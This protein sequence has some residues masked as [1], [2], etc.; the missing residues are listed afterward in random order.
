LARLGAFFAARAR[1]GVAYVLHLR[2]GGIMYL[3]EAVRHYRRAHAAFSATAALTDGR[4]VADLAFGDRD[5]ER[6]H[7]TDR[8]PAITADLVE[9]EAELAETEAERGPAVPDL[10]RRRRRPTPPTFEVTIADTFIPGEPLAVQIALTGNGTWDVQLHYR[11]LNQ[12]E[13]WAATTMDT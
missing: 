3:R 11:H 6:G 13:R 10:A 9:L 12:G 5:S 1:A 4:Y 2:L 8:L 7:W